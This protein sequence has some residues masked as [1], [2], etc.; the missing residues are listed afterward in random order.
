LLGR[1]AVLFQ[2]PKLNQDEAMFCKD[3]A[4]SYFN[5]QNRRRAYLLPSWTRLRPEI[6]FKKLAQRAFVSLSSHSSWENACAS[7]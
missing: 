5:F 3:G 6:I 4:P 7:G 1:G 2:F